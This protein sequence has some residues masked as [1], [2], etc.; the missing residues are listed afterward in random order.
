MFILG[1]DEGLILKCNEAF[2]DVDEDKVQSWSQLK[3]VSQSSTVARSNKFWRA[4]GQSNLACRL[5]G[6]LFHWPKCSTKSLK[7]KL[8]W[9]L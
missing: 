4:T 2:I 1:E 5:N 6:S 3:P 9:E 8:F 7:T